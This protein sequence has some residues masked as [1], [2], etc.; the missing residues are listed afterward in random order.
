MKLTCKKCLVS[1]DCSEFYKHSGMKTGY[2]ST[3]RECK[4][5]ESRANPSNRKT[6]KLSDAQRKSMQE[7]RNKYPN[8]AEAHRIVSQAIQSGVLR[9][10]PCECC[11]AIIAAAHHDDYLKPLKVRWLCRTHHAEWHRLN[12]EA[13]N[14]K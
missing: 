5:K 9:K 10:Q 7:Y 6:R 2:L 1:K 14:G 8:K 13:L 12:G 3:C 4:K 11:G